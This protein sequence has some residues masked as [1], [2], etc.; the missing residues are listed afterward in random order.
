MNPKDAATVI[1]DVVE[2]T[3]EE[4]TKQGLLRARKGK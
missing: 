3:V 2:A 4:M 1:A